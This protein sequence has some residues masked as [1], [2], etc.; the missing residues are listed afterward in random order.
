[1]RHVFDLKICRR[2]AARI[3]KACSS[4]RRS[5]GRTLE[6]RN[7]SFGIGRPGIGRIRRPDEIARHVVGL[8]LGP[9]SIGIH[10]AGQL[11]KAR[12][13]ARMALAGRI[14]T[15]GQATSSRVS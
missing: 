8:P 6:N 2:L 11:Q 10:S 4:P 3:P 12:M 7:G 5:C 15:A 1:L 13:L 9:R 14:R